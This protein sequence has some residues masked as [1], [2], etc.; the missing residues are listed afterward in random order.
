[1]SY[2]VV[3]QFVALVGEAEARA[4]ATPTPPATGYD[5]TKIQGALDRASATLDSY[6]AT[7]FTVPLAPV[8]DIVATNACILAR[9]ELDRQGRDFVLKAA[10]RVRAWAKDV[11]AGR[12]TLGVTAGSAQDPETTSGGA[13]VLIDAPDR[14]FDD[15]GLAPFLGGC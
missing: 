13:A 12:A 9:E 15:A 5:A 8:P 2:A 11:A 7:R 6:F 3:S 1:M 14:V 4:L 10:D